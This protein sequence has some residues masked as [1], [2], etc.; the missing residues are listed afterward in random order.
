[1]RGAQGCAWCA[2]GRPGA[3]PATSGAEGSVGNGRYGK[4]VGSDG[5]NEAPSGVYSG[6]GGRTKW[7]RMLTGQG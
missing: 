4:V 7:W 5:E 6:F 1:M 2:S 3:A